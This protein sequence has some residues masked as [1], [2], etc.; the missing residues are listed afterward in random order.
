MFKDLASIKFVVSLAA[1]RY[2]SIAQKVKL[3]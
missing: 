3:R 1:V 2:D